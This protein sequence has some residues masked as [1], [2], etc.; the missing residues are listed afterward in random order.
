MGDM[1]RIRVRIIQESH[2]LKVGDEKN[3]QPNVAIQ[4]IKAGIAEQVTTV[5][6]VAPKKHIVKKVEVEVEAIELTAPIEQL[7]DAVD[8][9][10]VTV[11]DWNDLTRAELIEQCKEKGIEVPRNAKKAELIA[12]LS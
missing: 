8:T 4:L 2:G 3:L 10:T 9:I 12:L 6:A 5:D 11:D 1:T 7:I